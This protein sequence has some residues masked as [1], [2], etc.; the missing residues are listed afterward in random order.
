MIELEHQLRRDVG[1]LCDLGPRALSLG[2][3]DAACDVLVD[4]IGDGWQIDRQPFETP[5]GVARNLELRHPR[6]PADPNGPVLVVGAH[7]DTWRDTPGADDNA[8]AVACLLQMLA[9]LGDLAAEGLVRFVLYANEEP[10]YFQTRHMG[11]LHHARRCRDRGWDVE[12]LCLESLGYFSDKPG[13][14]EDPSAAMNPLVLAG[15]AKLLGLSRIPDGGLLGD[16]GDFLVLEADVASA[17]LLRRLRDGYMRPLHPEVSMVRLI[18]AALPQRFCTGLSDHW[19]YWQCGY[20]AVMATDTALYRN[21]NY[22]EP[23]DTPDTLDYPRLAAVTRR[24]THA[25]RHGVGH[26][27]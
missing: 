17:K 14:Q 20:P 16:V 1:L 26:Q 22:H 5:D 27:F 19:S 7:Y 4:R 6:A 8:S 24:L 3:L 18:P 2:T 13:S 9:E 11:S 12:M 23:T 10:P 15:A 25:V 21:P